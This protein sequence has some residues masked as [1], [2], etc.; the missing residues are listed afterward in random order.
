MQVRRA[1]ALLLALLL[2]GLGTQAVNTL[3]SSA[4]E[5]YRTMKQLALS[6]D[7]ALRLQAQLALEELNKGIKEGIFESKPMEKR[8]FITSAPPK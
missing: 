3:G 8:I 6:E 7:D 2:Q 4:L 5:V 1:A